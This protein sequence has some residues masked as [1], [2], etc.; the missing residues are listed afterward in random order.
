MGQGTFSDFRAQHS[1]SSQRHA[2]NELTSD[3]TSLYT[4]AT[5]DP[6]LEEFPLEWRASKDEPLLRAQGETKK[7]T[8]GNM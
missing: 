7:G 6:P 2:C 3:T 8:I 1:A 5:C 4:C